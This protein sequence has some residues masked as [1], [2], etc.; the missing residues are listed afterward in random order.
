MPL[1]AALEALGD[2]GSMGRRTA[3]VPLDQVV[4]SAGRPDDFDADFR[5][6]SR[7]LRERLQRIQLA[8]Q[9]G[10]H[11]P[12]VDLIQLGE[13]YFVVDGHHR[14]AAART[15]GQLLIDAHV[16][17]ICTIAYGM[18]CLRLA[19]LG[20]KSAERSFLERIPLPDDLRRDLW[21]DRPVDWMRLATAAE[22][23]GYRRLLEVG[24]PMDRS[25]LAE[26]WWRHE[27]VP[28]LD[29]LRTCGVGLDLRDVEL[30]ATAIAVRDREGLT[31]WPEDLSV[32]MQQPQRV[33]G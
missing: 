22:S 10:H 12:P 26:D 8:R 5:P 17:H 24:R 13:L 31:D 25:E 11:L 30:Y 21:L 9:A 6:T 4:G 2:G 32:R 19:D 7:H 3:T 28:V 23:W 18:A 27:V 29:R 1:D 20:S 16:V 33:L 14:I 15:A